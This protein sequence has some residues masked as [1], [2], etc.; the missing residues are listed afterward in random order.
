MV[1]ELSPFSSLAEELER[2]REI[3]E[4]CLQMKCQ[5]MSLVSRLTVISETVYTS[6]FSSD[7]VVKLVM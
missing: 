3:D 5:Q 2:T 6:A 7:A 1:P 4:I